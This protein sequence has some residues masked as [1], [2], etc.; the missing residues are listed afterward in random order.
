MSNYTRIYLARKLRDGQRSHTARSHKQFPLRRVLI[1][2]SDHVAHRR[3]ETRSLDGAASRQRRDKRRRKSRNRGKPRQRRRKHREHRRKSPGLS[4]VRGRLRRKRANLE[5]GSRDS[6]YSGYEEPTI[7]DSL[8]VLDA[9]L[10][11]REKK[12]KRELTDVGSVFAAANGSV[13]DP[14]PIKGKNRL[15]DEVTLLNKR[16]AWKRENEKQLEEVAFGRDMRNGAKRVRVLDEKLTEASKP[17]SSVD[18]AGA[19]TKRENVLGETSAYPGVDR[20]D[21]GSR[22]ASGTD[23]GE[24]SG[25]NLTTGENDRVD[26]GA[27]QP[28]VVSLAER[29]IN[30]FADNEVEATSDAGVGAAEKLALNARTDNRVKGKLGAINCETKIDNADGGAS[31]VNLTSDAKKPPRVSEERRKVSEA[32]EEAD[33]NVVKLN[34]ATKYRAEEIDPEIEL[35]DLGRA[36]G[37]GGIYGVADWRDSI[38]GEDNLFGD[39]LGEGDAVELDE[40][41][42]LDPAYNLGLLRLRS[43]KRSGD[44]VEWKMTPIIKRSRYYDGRA[45]PRLRL[46][47]E[48]R[49]PILSGVEEIDPGAYL[50]DPPARRAAQ[51]RHRVGRDGVFFDIAPTLRIIDVDEGGIRT[52]VRRA[53]EPPRRGDRRTDPRVS[54]GPRRLS[55]SK[56]DRRS[57]NAA[58]VGTYPVLKGSNREFRDTRFRSDPEPDRTIY[59]VVR[60]P[61]SV[62]SGRYYD[63]LAD[64]SPTSR[65]VP[66]ILGRD[67]DDVYRYP[68]GAYLEY[69]PFKARPRGS[70]RRVARRNAGHRAKVSERVADSPANDLANGRS[71]G[72]R[73]ARE[74]SRDPAVANRE[75]HF[76]RD[77]AGC[78]QSVIESNGTETRLEG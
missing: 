1:F 39:K 41:G 29:R 30:V 23:D 22:A 75:D 28:D 6:L 19:R 16:E 45:P 21:R 25:R 20:S 59:D 72:R 66:A 34:R 17:R 69:G 50:N 14:L 54:L 49:M 77:D 11:A 63:D 76:A 46:T 67:G 68:A 53:R 71:S 33:G 7:Y 2:F 56:G 32:S 70:N 5:E 47:R 62:R 3:R 31:F 36:R 37:L 15:E 40:P 12:D 18:E 42:D 13:L 55:R 78:A 4:P 48:R 10:T 27:T 24:E 43:N 44:V 35:R 52:G 58:E 51:Q 8:D 38:Y 9:K 65:L 26:N 74:K 57:N 73:Y 60:S 61:L 64:L